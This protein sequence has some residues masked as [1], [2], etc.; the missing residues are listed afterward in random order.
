MPPNTIGRY[1]IER[2]LGRGGMAVVYLGLDPAMQRSVAIKVLPRQFTFDPHFRVRFQREAQLIATLEHPFIVPVYDYGEEDDQPFIVMRFMPGGS[3]LDR[4]KRGPLP[5][6]QIV[7]IVNR[8][9]EALD[10]AHARRII[11]RDLKPGNVLFDARGEAFLSD[12]GIAKMTESGSTTSSTGVMGTPAYMSPEQAR[13]VKDLDGRSDIYSL[14][15]MLYEL[16]C[17][18]LPY[19]AD[20]PM[21]MAVAHITEPVP[22]ILNVKPDLPEPVDRFIERTL[23][24]DPAERFQ[25]A[26][27]LA[28][29]LADIAAG[30]GEGVTAASAAPSAA[31]PAPRGGAPSIPITPTLPPAVSSAVS[32]AAPASAA[33][34]APRRWWIPALIGLGAL[35][36]CGG[37]ILGGWM[38]SA[39]GLWPGLTPVVVTA[40]PAPPSATPAVIIVEITST[41]APPTMTPR[42]SDTPAP[43]TATPTPTS[44]PTATPTRHIASGEPRGRIVFTCFDGNDDEVCL[45]NADGS[46]LTQL[47]DND[48]GDW[49]A[50]LSPDGQ[51]VLFS[52]QIRGSN[53]EIFRMG[54]DGSNVTPLT[55]NGAQNYAPAFSPDGARIAYV[56]T[57]GNANQQIWLMNADGGG[58]VA[59]TTT[60]GNVDPSWSPDG[61]RIAFA[62][63]RTGRQQLWVMNADGSD[64]RQVTDLL[65]MGGRN[66]FSA[67]GARLVFYAGPRPNRQIYT[68][69]VDGSGLQQL[70]TEGD[71]AGPTFAP[72]G[73]WIAFASF[74]ESDNEIVIVRADG[75][76]RRVLTQNATSDYQPRWGP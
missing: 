37:L 64:P 29:D 24:K 40:T 59:L 34:S 15:V 12:F 33:P 41:P 49:Y 6:A 75:S 73:Q 54:T 67:D 3:L 66:A 63:L 19:K 50:S 14:G 32:S 28:R 48:F 16:L 26:R 53:Y 21:G 22:H 30:R 51:S 9:A 42:P 31:P 27:A 2:E 18:Q 44:I 43:A 8:I 56:S 17:G 20:T 57:S 45:M 61:T 38:L 69:N 62:S 70:T 13:G 55:Q 36:C 58:A 47:T 4:M 76:D 1:R 39:R 72:D 23:A 7:S 74:V 68:I 11:H 35:V 46:G 65:E 10:E 60:S 5:L 71:N 52:R 25:T